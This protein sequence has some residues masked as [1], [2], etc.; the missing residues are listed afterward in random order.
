M[1]T[2]QSKP[3]TKTSTAKSRREVCPEGS[4]KDLWMVMQKCELS[5]SCLRETAHLT[6]HIHKIRLHTPN[7]SSHTFSTGY[8]FTKTCI[9]SQ[10]LHSLISKMML[11]PVMMMMTM[12][13]MIKM[14]ILL[15]CCAARY[16]SSYCHSKLGHY[17]SHTLQTVTVRKEERS[18]ERAKRVGGTPVLLCHYLLDLKYKKG[19]R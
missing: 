3:Y 5:Y 12:M 13:M 10:R 15:F 11:L 19:R 9:S 18:V 6:D 16:A 2:S 4:F 7:H 1:Y 8:L 14:G 17:V